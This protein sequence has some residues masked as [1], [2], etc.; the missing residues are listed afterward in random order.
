M[1]DGG[2]IGRGGSFAVSGDMERVEFKLLTAWTQEQDLSP[3]KEKLNLDE[4]RYKELSNKLIKK[5]NQEKIK[6]ALYL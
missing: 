5:P 2:E 6:Q 3:H 1:I 4:T